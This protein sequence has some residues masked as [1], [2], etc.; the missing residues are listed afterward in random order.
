MTEV[1]ELS[2]T[3]VAVRLLPLLKEYAAKMSDFARDA[4]RALDACAARR[5]SGPLEV[6]RLLCF[7]DALDKPITDVARQASG[8]VEHSALEYF[9]KTEL[10]LRLDE[11]EE[12]IKFSWLL[13]D[14]L[15]TKVVANRDYR[16]D[17]DRLRGLVED[18]AGRYKAPF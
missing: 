7:H 17:M 10:K 1:A 15:R 4:E 9:L 3:E 8:L 11:L 12:H 16:S 13:I 2:A 5:P 18:K 6:V 14:E